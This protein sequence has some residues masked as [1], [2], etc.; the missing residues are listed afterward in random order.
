MDK[1]LVCGGTPFAQGSDYINLRPLDKKFSI[2]SEFCL[3]CGEVSSIKNHESKKSR[4]V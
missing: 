1:C 4:G 3:S 2:G